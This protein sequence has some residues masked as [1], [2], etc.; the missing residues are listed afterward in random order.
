[1][2]EH[3]EEFRGYGGKFTDTLGLVEA[4]QRGESRRISMR[5]ATA[6]LAAAE[7]HL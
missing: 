2:K 7:T 1:M 4:V 5:D 3:P 6:I